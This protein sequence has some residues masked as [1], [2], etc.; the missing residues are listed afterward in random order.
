MVINNL[1]IYFS[2]LIKK[3]IIVF[4]KRNIISFLISKTKKFFQKLKKTFFD[5]LILEDLNL[6]KLIR[7]K[8]D[9]FKKSE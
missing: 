5:N 4:F 1:G 9:K 2:K 3:I 6:F 7:L 8:K